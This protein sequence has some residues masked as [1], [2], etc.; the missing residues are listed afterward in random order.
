MM[1]KILLSVIIIIAFLSYNGFFEKTVSKQIKN[2]SETKISGAYEAL[3][4]QGA[5]QA[6][7]STSLPKEAHFDAWQKWNSRDVNSQ[8]FIAEPW[9]SLG[10]H[11]RAGRTLTIALNPQNENT[12]YAGSASGGL[13]RSYTAGVGAEAWEKVE[14]GY[15]ILSV[16]DIAFHPTDSMTIYIGTGEVYN[17]EAAGTGAAYRNTRGSYGM[18]ILKTEDGGNTWSKSLDWSYNQQHG[19]WMIK[20]DPQNTDIVYAATTQ[21]IYKSL[22]AGGNWQQVLDVVM[23]TDLLIHPDNPNIVVASCGNFASPGYGIYR[24]ENGGDTWTQITSDLPTNFLG[25]TQLAMSPSNTDIIYASIGN[26][27]S[28]PDG[29]TWLCQSEDFGSTWTINSTEDY[30]RWQGW[31]SHDVAISPVDPDEVVTIGINVWYSND[32]GDSLSRVTTGGSGF[33]NAPIEGP[34]GSSTYVHS[35][36]HDIIINPTNH[37]SFYVASDGGIHR[38]DDGGVNWYSAN[39]G[40]QTAQFYNGTSTSQNSTDLYIGG[41]QDNGTI[42]WNGDLTWRR[43]AGGDGSWTAINPDDD[44]IFFVSSQNLY[45]SRTLNGGNNFSLMDWGDTYRA[46]TAFIAPFVIA[47][48]NGMVGYAGSSNMAKSMNGGNTWEVINE[49]NPL[50]GNPILSIEVSP[51]DENVVYAG[52]APFDGQRSHVFSTQDG[53]VF[54][55]ITADLPD[56]FPMDITVDPTDPATAYVVFSGFG[57]GHVFKTQDY[58]QTWEDIS[59]NLP[60]VPTNAIIVDPVFPQHIYVGNDLGVFVTTEGGKIWESYQDGL[61]TATM[62][63]DLE[64]SNPTRKLRAATHGNGAF[65]RDLLDD[66]SAVVGEFKSVF[67]LKVFPNPVVNTVTIEFENNANQFVKL[68]LLGIDGRILKPL[69]FKKIASGAHTFS[70]NLSAIQAGTYFIRFKSEEYQSVSKLVKN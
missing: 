26:G 62:V 43:I 51:Q 13:W 67:E 11:N 69:L 70:F 60:D 32:G 68:D 45:V 15:P 64:I 44:D 39:G 36:A 1:K 54:T 59:G 47:P 42:R 48:S 23:G 31:F 40:Y 24:S 61:S 66:P 35:D 57:S 50:D 19:V 4:F 52:T 37:K 10:P 65:Q 5:R 49:G 9:E 2:A 20:I 30:S 17:Y 16:S 46:P 18:G 58:G 28:G 55:D 21:G 14:T 38:S 33:S 53:N 29:K 63:F 3:N 56:R 7:P 34:D 22:D 41:L 27:F 12:L 6:Y 25:K 8:R